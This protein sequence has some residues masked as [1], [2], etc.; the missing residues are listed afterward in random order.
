MEKGYMIVKRERITV[1][2]YMKWRA[3]MERTYGPMYYRGTK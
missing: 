3:L 1:E 2:A